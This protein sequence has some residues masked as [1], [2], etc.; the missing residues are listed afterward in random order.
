MLFIYIYIYIYIKKHL[1]NVLFNNAKYKKILNNINRR[2]S[3]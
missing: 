1:N 3:Q 2:D